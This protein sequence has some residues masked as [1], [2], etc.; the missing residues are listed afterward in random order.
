MNH[1]SDQ[2]RVPTETRPRWQTHEYVCALLERVLTPG[3][4]VQHDI[5]LPVIN[6]NR[7]RQC[8]VV[9]RFGTAPR[10]MTAIVEVTSRGR[11]VGVNDIHAWYRKMQEVGAQLLICVSRVGFSRSA[12]AV[13]EQQYGPS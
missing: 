4:S 8:D 2:Q 13:V 10:E 5:R 9:V 6:G 11:K 7:M 1:D 3:A 12:I